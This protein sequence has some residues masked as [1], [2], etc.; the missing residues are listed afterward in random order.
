RRTALE[1]VAILAAL[2]VFV[3]P[4]VFMVLTSV[5]TEDQSADLSFSWPTSWPGV[6]NLKDVLS[7]RNYMLLPAFTSSL[8]LAVVSVAILVVLC[9]TLGFVLQRR[10]GPLAS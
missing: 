3:V 7:A 5:K 8:I 1:I 9:A 2:V 4:F 6:Q 10:P